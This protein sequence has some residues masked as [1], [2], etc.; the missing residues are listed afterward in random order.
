MGKKKYSN[1][2]YYRYKYYNMYQDYLVNSNINNIST[3]NNDRYNYFFLFENYIN[4]DIIDKKITNPL[5]KKKHS[6][7]Y[8]Y[9]SLY[10][11]PP[12]IPPPN[13][14]YI[15][16][17]RTS[18]IISKLFFNKKDASNNT[19]MSDSGFFSSL[20]PFTPSL[21][22]LEKEEEPV[23]NITLELTKE[24]KE[25]DF[26][27]LN[28]KID[29][30]KD[31]I[32]LGKKYQTEYKDK[33]K[34]YNINLK[35]L[36]GLVNPLE[37][38]DNMIGMEN[39]KKAIF[40][41]IIFYLQGLE[42]KNTDYNHIVLC[43]GPGMGKTHVAKIIGKIYTKLGF[44]SK[45]NFKEIKLTDL[46]AGYVGQT[47]IKT[48][49]LLDDSKG[50]ILFFD[51]AY[52]LG[53]EKKF[54]SFSQSVIDVINPFLDKYKNDFIFIIAGYKQDLE[55]RF[56]R[57][58]QGL[59]SRFGLWLEI[60]KYKAADLNFMFKKKIKD[61]EWE[62]KSDEITDSFFEKNIDCFK[63][64][65]RDIENLFAKCKIAHAKRVLFSKP[66]DKKKITKEDLN[67]GFELYKIEGRSDIPENSNIKNFMYI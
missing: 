28:E 41:K 4:D 17:N 31:L 19:G 10:I 46:K 26:E 55:E 59:K 14:D 61:H 62:Y 2:Y 48:Q 39:I 37:D 34:R 20:R 63:F 38:L 7:K 56:F 66:E 60:E 6:P 5:Y 57:G 64:Y 1:K 47:E 33:K 45:G 58:N 18:H 13:L 15:N 40:N 36:E 27:L 22:I 67:K 49:K 42:N 35:V 50:S 23:N 53:S 9:K 8:I 16:N 51:E 24:E 30:I 32:I 52:S 25:Y 44:L 54:D 12:P 21:S 11:P 29:N 3:L 65:G 43:G